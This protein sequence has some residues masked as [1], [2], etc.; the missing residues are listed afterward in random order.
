MEWCNAHDAI[1]SGNLSALRQIFQLPDLEQW[2]LL[3][4]LTEKPASSFSFV[5]DVLHLASS[6][7][8]AGVLRCFL[9]FLE[10]VSDHP[11]C[12]FLD[13]QDNVGRTPLH[14]AIYR[15]RSSCIS[16]L[17][18]FGAGL[19]IED[20]LGYTPKGLLTTNLVISLLTSHVTEFQRIPLFLAQQILPTL[21]YNGDFNGIDHL[22]DVVPTLD[23]S[24]KDNM[25]RTAVHEA[26]Q[27]G[28]VQVL[29][30]LLDAGADCNAQ[31]WRGSTPLHYA[32]NSKQLDCIQIL[33]DQPHVKM[34]LTEKSTQRS[35][36]HV[37][38][39]QKK[40]DVLAM[41]LD[42]SDRMSLIKGND[43]LSSQIAKNIMDLDRLEFPPI[44]I[45]C[46]AMED[47][48]LLMRY[49]AL[50]GDAN[51]VE[52]CIKHLPSIDAINSQDQTGRTVLHDAT[53]SRQV[54][55]VHILV[56][57]GANVMVQDWRGSTSLHSAATRGD[58]AIVTALISSN[59]GIVSVRSASGCTPLLLALNYKQWECA[60]LILDRCS[61][62]DLLEVDSL[63]HTALHK[64]VLSGNDTL[65]K[66]IVHSM[67]QCQ[68]LDSYVDGVPWFVRSS[69]SLY[70]FHS[71][72][73]L[74]HVVISK[75]KL[76]YLSE[77]S[78][79]SRSQFFPGSL[80]HGF[81]NVDDESSVS[82]W[83]LL[84]KSKSL[85]E[86]RRIVMELDQ[87][88]IQCYSKRHWDCLHKL[89]SEC[90]VLDKS[91]QQWDITKLK[92][93]LKKVTD[94][95][96]MAVKPN[97][98]QKDGRAQ[99]SVAENDKSDPQ[100]LLPT[101]L[102]KLPSA[103]AITRAQ[104]EEI[105]RGIPVIQKSFSEMIVGLSSEFNQFLCHI[106]L[107]ASRKGLWQL[108]L[109]ESDCQWLMNVWCYGLR[110]F[111]KDAGE[112][113]VEVVK[114]S[115]SSD[116]QSLKILFQSAISAVSKNR[117]LL[118]AYEHVFCEALSAVGAIPF[119]YVPLIAQFCAPFV[120]KAFQ[121]LCRQGSFCIT[122]NA[123]IEEPR[124][125]LA[126]SEIIIREE[127]VS[128][129]LSLRVACSTFCCL[130]SAAVRN[131]SSLL[132]EAAS[133]G[134]TEVC[135]SLLDGKFCCP[136]IDINAKDV[137]CLT[138]LDRAVVGGHCEVTLVLLAYGATR[139]DTDG[140]KCLL[141]T[142]CSAVAAR[143]NRYDCLST[144][145]ELIS[146]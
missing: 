43:H 78:H 144:L 74:R 5:P 59:T 36:V 28:H 33:I 42:R 47:V 31:D 46:L 69:L 124:D 139:G 26:S 136:F 117:E 25:G 49:F 15:L 55:V 138:S 133:E 66:L 58:T 79:S 2:G 105:K 111:D 61:P 83:R 90:V 17:L 7:G 87:C 98:L 122:R 11:L 75:L 84:V 80:L 118:S 51:L 22:L 93:F 109:W 63:G 45:S 100:K 24:M 115:L 86:L 125:Y 131:Q 103:P 146:R 35:A 91:G 134:L 97:P 142:L 120:G 95:Y 127:Q 114:R 14:C 143:D 12:A 77:S 23:V 8:Q 64:V 99:Q 67:S 137:Q 140:Q 32:V 21:A 6:L 92:I 129:A 60:R 13:L 107:L 70:K 41:F 62:A 27:M 108:L 102:M 34:D 20:K 68:L 10:Q 18:E 57:N 1:V 56:A 81:V 29:C 30:Q 48:N 88:L 106:L 116:W 19:D 121:K 89:I 110:L 72:H 40:M 39:L 128:N 76:Y 141:S 130:V 123:T 82:Q 104:N 96:L 65:M 73:L 112:V 132:H 9:D 54:A 3:L 4:G 44:V 85:S 50:K 145:R 126:M 101:L 37:A 119:Q 16:V 52:M 71:Q 94:D 53:D 113:L 38:I 135:S